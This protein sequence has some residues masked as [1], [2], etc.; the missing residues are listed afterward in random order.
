MSPA[1]AGAPRSAGRRYAA[2]ITACFN[3]LSERVHAPLPSCRLRRHQARGG[4]ALGSKA[5]I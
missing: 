3:I 4:R 1:A 5:L 2:L